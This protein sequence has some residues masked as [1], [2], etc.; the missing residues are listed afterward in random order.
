MLYF[1]SRKDDL[2]PATLTHAYFAMDIYDHLTIGLKKLLMDDKVRLRMFSQGMDPLY[3][4]NLIS[5]KDGKKVQQ[6]GSY[7][8]RNKS[9]DFFINLVNYIKYNR[10]YKNPQVMAFLYGMISHYILDSTIHPYIFYKTGQLKKEDP[11][12]YRYRNHHDYMETFIDNYMIKQ[13]E[14]IHPYRFKFYQYCFQLEPF[15]DE[16]N[17][18]IDYAFEETFHIHHMSKFYYQALKQMHFCLKYFRYDKSGLKM[19]LYQGLD[20]IKPKNTFQLQAISYHRKLNDENHYLNLNHT[21]WLHP[22]TKREKH[23]ESF[24]ELYM[25]ALHN[26]DTLIKDVNAYLKD[27][28]K[29]NLKKVFTNLSYLSGKNCNKGDQFQFFEW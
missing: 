1:Y 28:K 12:T 21:S 2:M 8:H 10:Y 9:Q 15:N 20:K 25:I 13:K 26:A 6:F 4:Y 23:N 3:F 11:S 16:L 24:L 29:I 14:N 22:A 27:T 17:E 5:L 18:V 7:F 19:K